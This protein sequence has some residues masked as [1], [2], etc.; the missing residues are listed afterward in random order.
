MFAIA[1]CESRE[2]SDAIKILEYIDSLL[3][4][5][6]NPVLCYYNAVCLTRLGRLQEA[7]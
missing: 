3:Q 7:V 5:R 1:S 2:Y 4:I 6:Q